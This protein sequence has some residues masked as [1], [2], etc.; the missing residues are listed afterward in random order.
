M[1]Q[2]SNVTLA[3]GV[4]WDVIDKTVEVHPSMVADYVR[5]GWIVLASYMGREDI[6]ENV[7]ENGYYQQKTRS[8][9]KPV[10]LMGQTIVDSMREEIAILR[11]KDAQL[12][13]CESDLAELRK[14]HESCEKTLAE[15]RASERRGWDSAETSRKAREDADLK[16]L[17]METDIGKLRAALGEIR[18]K[19]ILGS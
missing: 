3:A 5:Q 13:Q 17:K 19:E 12:R 10:V 4:R 18:M 8:E 2:S 16:R 7:T 9:Y 14:K 1:M 15:V 11:V 6:H